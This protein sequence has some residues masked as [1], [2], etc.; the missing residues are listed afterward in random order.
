MTKLPKAKVPRQKKARK[1]LS[2][3]GAAVRGKK[4]SQR[5]TILGMFRQ[6]RAERRWLKLTELMDARIPGYNGVI[7]RLRAGG[8]DTK[9]DANRDKKGRQRPRYRMVFDQERDS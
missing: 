9:Y 6:A 4:I 7:C 8:Y 3:M 2:L 1:A 5:E